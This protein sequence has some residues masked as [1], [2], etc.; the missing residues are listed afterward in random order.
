[1]KRGRSLQNLKDCTHTQNIC[2]CDEKSA[3]HNQQLPI[4]MKCDSNNCINKV[5]STDACQFNIQNSSSSE[6]TNSV[7]S[8]NSYFID[9]NNKTHG[10]L[11][12][13]EGSSSLLSLQDDFD[14]KSGKWHRNTSCHTPPLCKSFAG[15]ELA[16]GE[17]SPASPSEINNSFYNAKFEHVD[18]R[19][20]PDKNGCNGSHKSNSLEHDYLEEELDPS[21]LI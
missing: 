12:R 13:T 6:S 4:I 16:S 5:I 14:M 10:T 1:M 2:N 3:Q 7:N 15:I 8:N 21:L 11:K 18:I 19:D 9:F 17:R 20:I